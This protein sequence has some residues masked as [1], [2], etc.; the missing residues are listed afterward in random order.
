MESLSK[1]PFRGK[2]LLFFPPDRQLTKEFEASALMSGPRLSFGLASMAMYAR[3]QGGIEAYVYSSAD[4]S[5]EAVAKIIRAQKPTV[6]GVSCSSYNRF[7]CLTLARIAKKIDPDIIV[8]FGGVHATFL[9]EQILAHYPEV[10]YIVRGQGEVTFFKLLAA[11]GGDGDIN[12]VDGLTF[13][14][15]GAFVRTPHHKWFKTLDDLPLID[16]KAI[17]IGTFESGDIFDAANALPVETSRGC[18]FSCM[19]CSSVGFMGPGVARRSVCK[20]MEQI[21]LILEMDSEGIF[22][23]DMN[24]TLDRRYTIELCTEM[25]RHKI[26]IPWVC[27]TR[28]DLVDEELLVLLR[29]AGCRRIFY[30][31][32]SLCKKVLYSV[33]RKYEPS[34]A[35][36]N[37]NLT[38]SLGINTNI[39]LIIGFPGETDKDRLETLRN[40]S[41]I[42]KDIH[43]GV[44][45]LM[46]FPGAELYAIA[47]RN[48][49]D[50]S[51]WLDEHEE[52]FPYYTGALSKDEMHSWMR[53]FETHQQR[54]TIC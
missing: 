17:S 1:N 10:D 20:V 45:G 40:T 52:V 4:H 26:K 37:L 9:D 30:G 5:P 16:Y 31:V 34:L 46:I 36:K 21:D 32:D 19:F 23:H 14:K 47:L 35:I 41:K 6:I 15:D 18:P 25:L 39:N 38:A 27:M 44:N 43:V 29:Q 33:G 12:S 42:H 24:F 7:S 2:V 3:H 51:Y 28:I 53:H 13:R 8:V 50:E 11:L 48:G 49:F 54:A 22:F